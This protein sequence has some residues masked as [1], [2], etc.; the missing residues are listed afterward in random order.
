VLGWQIN[1]GL[2]L[3]TALED[4]SVRAINCASV[5]I[6]HREIL[7]EGG[8][9]LLSAGLIKAGLEPLGQISIFRAMVAVGGGKGAVRLNVRWGIEG[10]FILVGNERP[11]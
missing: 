5:W 9:P 4:K 3:I 8:W 7:C 10:D 6:L 1:G 11:V 2:D